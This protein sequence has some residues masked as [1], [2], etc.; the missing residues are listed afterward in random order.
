M[1]I[2][3]P[4]VYCTLVM[5]FDPAPIA[6]IVCHVTS[7]YDHPPLTQKYNHELLRDFQ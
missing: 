2:F 7:H 1:L 4:I 6:S 3:L 5:L